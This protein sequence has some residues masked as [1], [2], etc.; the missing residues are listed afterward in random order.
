MTSGATLSFHACPEA[1][2]LRHFYWQLFATL[3]FVEPPTTRAA[4]LPL[5]FAWLRD[6]ARAG[7]IHFKRLMWVLRFEIGTKGDR[8]HYHL[9]LAGVPRAL[10]SQ[11]LCRSL[12]SAW[13]A[14]GGGLSEVTLYDQARDGLSYVLKLRLMV[15]GVKVTRTGSFR[16]SNDDCEPMLSVSLIEAV[17]RGRM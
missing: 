15:E 7:R 13:R 6:V 17:R 4:S 2:A 16:I 12:E 5:V 11:H 3:T 9:C 14:R 10:L 1:Y 8:G